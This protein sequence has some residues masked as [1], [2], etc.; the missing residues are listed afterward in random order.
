MKFPRIGNIDGLFRAMPAG[1]GRTPCLVCRKR[2]AIALSLASRGALL[3]FP[4][5]DEP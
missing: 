5:G 3:P 2:G 1:Q 4:P